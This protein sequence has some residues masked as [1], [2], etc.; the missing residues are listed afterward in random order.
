MVLAIPGDPW[1]LQ[2]AG[3]VERM[4]NPVN[5]RNG[6]WQGPQATMGAWRLI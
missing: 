5:I 2:G 3:K 4:P 6:Q 1:T